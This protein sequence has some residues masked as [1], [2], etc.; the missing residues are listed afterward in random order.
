MNNVKIQCFI[1]K[2]LYFECHCMTPVP[3]DRLLEATNLDK[4][5]AHMAINQFFFCLK[6][7]NC[8]G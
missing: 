5:S 4:F 7:L 3:A 8:A 2:I 1:N 6:K